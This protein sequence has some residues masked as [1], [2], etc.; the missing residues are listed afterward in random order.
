LSNRI[1]VW[2]VFGKDF[3]AY[4]LVPDQPTWEAI[5]RFVHERSLAPRI[6]T[7]EELFPVQVE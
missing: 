1:L 3:W 7:P 5:D 2:R 4:G 6:V